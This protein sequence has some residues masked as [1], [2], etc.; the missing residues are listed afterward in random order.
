MYFELEDFRPD[1]PRAPSVI[2]VREA[3]LLSFIAHLLCVIAYL[4]L[5][6]GFFE[7]PPQ[8]LQPPPQHDQVRFVAIEPRKD[9]SAPP[10]VAADQS[11]MDRRAASREQAPKPDNTMPFSRGN[12]PDKV[13]GAVP[14]R[15]ERAAGPDNPQPPAPASPT[16]PQ[17]PD[18]AAKILAEQQADQKPVGGG[19][20]GDRLRNIQSLLQGQNFDN[21]R[22]GQ[23]NKDPDIQFD[24]K[25]IDFGPWLRR[26][27]A[28]VMSNWF[29]PET[30][31]W[32]KGHVV[33]QF[34]VHRDGT[35]TDLAIMKPSSVD[36]FTTAA[37]NAMKLTQQARTQPLPAE[38]PTDKVLFTVTFFY[39][40]R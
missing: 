39:N 13:E 22:G 5:P 11:D 23:Q 7:A 1:T 29:I 9:R 36:S 25:G 18:L 27:R 38:Y 37:F 19:S 12:T 31:M 21:E 2:S 4:L 28:Q 34:Y 26:F 16:V 3:V 15:P 10:K 24:S 33:L 6:K 40:E 32:L 8:A 35:I 17:V 30:A 20:L 14:Q